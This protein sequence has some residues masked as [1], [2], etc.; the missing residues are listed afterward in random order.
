MIDIERDIK[1]KISNLRKLGVTAK[2]LIVD[3]NTHFEYIKTDPEFCPFSR[4]GDEKSRIYGLI[5]CLV[6][7]D[8]R[9]L[10]VI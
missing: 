1:V 5:V 2:Y 3:I 4:Y 8:T 10:D 6:D 7:G 9:F